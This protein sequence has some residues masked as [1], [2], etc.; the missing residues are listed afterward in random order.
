MC[1]NSTTTIMQLQQRHL[2]I[3]PKYL[4]FLHKPE[5]N[6]VRTA[7]CIA[8]GIRHHVHF[9]LSCKNIAQRWYKKLFKLMFEDHV[10]MYIK[11]NK[12]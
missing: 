10:H 1:T 9:L 6:Y 2:I 8:H 12:I 4:V 11:V 7:H 5:R 3:D